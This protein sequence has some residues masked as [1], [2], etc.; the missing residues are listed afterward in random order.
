MMREAMNEFRWDMVTK[1]NGR[2]YIC[3]CSRLHSARGEV[4]FFRLEGPEARVDTRYYRISRHFFDDVLTHVEKQIDD[5]DSQFFIEKVWGR[6]I[7]GDCR[8]SWWTEPPTIFGM[9]AT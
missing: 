1:C 7:Q 8:V 6:A 4:N 2:L 3:N 9:N 5:A